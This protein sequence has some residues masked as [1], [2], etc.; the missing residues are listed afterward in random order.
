MRRGDKVYYLS[1]DHLDSTSL[2]TDD[3]GAVVS[4]VRY[5]P[6]GQ[7]RWS[8]GA[9]G[10]LRYLLSDGLGSVRQAVDEAGEVV[11]SYEFDPYGNPVDNEG[12]EPYGFTGEWWEDEVGLL[13]LRA[14]WYDPETGRFL[15]QDPLSSMPAYAYASSNPINR[16]DPSGYIDWVSCIIG[17]DV[18]TCMLESGNT[19]W[20]IAREILYL[21]GNPDAYNRENPAINQH[22]NRVMVPQMWDLNPHLHSDLAWNCLACSLYNPAGN[23]YLPASW[24]KGFLTTPIPSSTSKVPS[25]GRPPSAG[26]PQP[27]LPPNDC[28]RPGPP[29]TRSVIVYSFDPAA[30][31]D[32]VIFPYGRPEGLP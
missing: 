32:I 11:A 12:G 6:Y 7:E 10:E 15:N 27:P 18:G 24:L 3:T 25:A 19:I 13:N 22:I 2:T 5:L 1:G 14:R 4:E 8:S 26:N 21:N 23:I 30:P 17:I 20:G 28:S 31:V 29:H 9:G 16:V